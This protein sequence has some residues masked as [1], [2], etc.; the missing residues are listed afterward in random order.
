MEDPFKRSYIVLYKFLLYK[1][2]QKGGSKVDILAGN[3][4]APTSQTTDA[5]K[6]CQRNNRNWL[7]WEYTIKM[8]SGAEQK[9]WPEISWKK[10][11]LMT[12]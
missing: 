1:S 7:L 11:H 4:L 3:N 2:R 12:F 8:K 9:S 5:G 10:L 6:Y